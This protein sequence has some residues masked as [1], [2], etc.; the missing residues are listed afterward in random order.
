MINLIRFTAFG[1]M[2]MAMGP[3]RDAPPP[4]QVNPPSPAEVD[5]AQS[6]RPAAPQDNG[7]PVL[8]ELLIHD[9]ADVD[10]EAF[11]WE[12]RPLVVFAETPSDPAFITQMQSL[13]DRPAALIER[14]VVVIFDADPAAN[15]VWRQELRPRGFSLV[16]LDKDGQAE[17]RK[18]RPWSVREISRAIDKFPMRREEIGRAGVLP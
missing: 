4:S 1:M 11:L 6:P 18:P 12:F 13:R 16:L 2:L 3:G 15:T 5:A 14:D 7:N 8:S 9:A 10:P 17:L